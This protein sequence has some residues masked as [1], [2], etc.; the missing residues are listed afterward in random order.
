M[1]WYD[2]TVI[3]KGVLKMISYRCEELRLFCT[4][5]TKPKK[6]GNMVKPI[7]KFFFIV[8]AVV[9]YPPLLSAQRG[10]L[11]EGD[12]VKIAASTISEKPLNGHVLH[13][14]DTDLSINSGGLYYFY[15]FH[16]I[17]H[18]ERSIGK[19]RNTKR[20]MIIGG[21]SGSLVTGLIEW[22]SYK[23]CQ[24]T[25]MWS[26]LYYPENRGTVLGQG[27]VT[28]AILGVASAIAFEKCEPGEFCLFNDKGAIIISN[29]FAGALIGGAA[30]LL[31]GTFIKTDRWMLVR[32]APR[33]G[34]AWNHHSAVP[35]VSLH[36]SLYNNRKH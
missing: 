25:G 18:I 36:F 1:V 19:K 33:S 28:G 8:A 12:K 3:I 4:D 24:Q 20:G 29:T 30:G 9:L 11:T 22:A 10:P 23:P 14:S 16:S 31:V 32:I 15:P 27:L 17:D 34:S 5:F 7:V 2:N 13:I 35:G 26:C 6:E 21:I